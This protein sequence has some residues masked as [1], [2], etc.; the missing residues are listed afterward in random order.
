[1]NTLHIASPSFL[2][3]RVL[4]FAV[5]LLLAASVVGAQVPAPPPSDDDA[6]VENLNELSLP[7]GGLEF[8]NPVHGGTA[9]TPQYDR[10]LYRMQW[11]DGDPIDVFVIRPH[12]VVRPPVV[13]Y[14]YGLPSTEERF[15]D[16]AFCR[17]V[18]RGGM[19]AIGFVPALTGERY[20]N[21]PLKQW[22]V[23]ELH[24]SIVKSVHDVQMVINYVETRS[25]IDAS[26]I[27]IFGQGAG[28][29]IVG[30][31][32]TVDKRIQAVEL[33]DPWGDWPTWL[34]SSPQISANERDEYRKPQFLEPLVPLD[35]LHWLPGLSGRQ[36]KVDE[37]L[38]EKVTPSA[39]KAR[40]ES[41]LPASALL[42]RY[43]SKDDFFRNALE[44]DRLLDW[45][46]KCLFP[47][48]TAS[49]TA[50]ASISARPIH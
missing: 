34:S 18:T 42:V 22:F 44:D 32:T 2:H 27:G 29:T 5:G 40:I 31:T 45:M 9:S 15:R 20:H 33:M 24:D 48:P 17:S 28:A 3:Q 12:G 43:T 36:L 46:R 41:A 19:A 21:L 6:A 47:L 13:L 50:A 39:S 38:F 14:L 35:P 4:G 8:M 26:R 11:R 49:I 7:A 23:S 30:L 37:A 10:E 16:D 1:M 25:D